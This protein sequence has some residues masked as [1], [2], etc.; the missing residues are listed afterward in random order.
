MPVVP[1]GRAE[2]AGNKSVGDPTAGIV[3]PQADWIHA[4]AGLLA[5]LLLAM[6]LLVGALL[7]W[8]DRTWGREHAARDDGPHVG[9]ADRRD[10]SGFAERRDSSGFADRRDHSAFAD[11]RDRSASSVDGY[12]SE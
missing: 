5:M 7:Y 3:A 8:R 11:R 6:L 12:D 4:H 1:G 10:H 2:K 9:F